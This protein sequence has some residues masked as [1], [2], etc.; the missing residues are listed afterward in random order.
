M[1]QQKQAAMGLTQPPV[2]GLSV[3]TD[4]AGIT[5]LGARS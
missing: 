2:A 3:L 1:S 4:S 5:T